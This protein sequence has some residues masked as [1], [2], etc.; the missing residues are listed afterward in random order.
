[1]TIEDKEGALELT[2]LRLRKKW[3]LQLQLNEIEQL[4][5]AIGTAYKEKKI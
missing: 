3:N 5:T 1:M 4:S 2:L